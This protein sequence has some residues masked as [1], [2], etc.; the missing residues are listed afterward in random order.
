MR[1]LSALL[2]GAAVLAAALGLAQLLK[3][4][5]AAGPAIAPP[6]GGARYPPA[7]QQQ[8]RAAAAAERGPPRTRHRLPSGAPI[9]TN[10]L[11]LEASPYLQ[12]HAHNP[13]DWFPWGDEAF[14]RAR[15]EHKPVLLSVGYSTCHWCHVMEEESFEDLEIADY[16]N[17]YYVAIKVDRE[18]RP[19]IDA[20]YM[21]AV[22]RMRGGGGWP[23]T[24]WL[25][26]DRQP[27]YGGTYFPPRDGVRGA[28]A[29]FL[30]VL[31]HLRAAYDQRPDDVAAAAADVAAQV[32]DSQTQPAGE[33][34]P[35][36]APLDGAVAA[37]RTQ[38]DATNGGF[39]GAPKFPRSVE[40]QLLL[41][42]YRR[43]GNA[44]ALAM[45]TRTLEAL[46]AGGIRDQIGGGFHRYSTDAGWRVPHFEKMLYDNALLALTFLD[47]CQV[48]GRADFAAVVRDILG[49]AQR[50][51]TAPDGAFYAA[52]DADS[53]GEEGTFFVWTPAE[54]QAVLTPGEWRVARAYY[55]V[56]DAGNFGGKN[57]LHAPRPLA[58]VANELGLP[59]PAAESLLRG[60]RTKLY[61]A[62]LQRVPPHTDHKILPAWNGLM[63]SAFA[64]GAQVL[65]DPADA[66]TAAAAATYV[67]DH[68]MQ[69][70]RLQRSALEGEAGGEAYLDDYAAMIG[71]LLDLYEATFDPRWLRAAIALERVV[72]AHFR[73][74]TDGGYFLSADD[75]EAL[76]VRTKPDYDGAEPSA[77][78][79]MLLDLLRLH[80]LTGDDRYRSRAADLLRAFTTKLGGS[81]DDLP[82]MLGGL[83]F[84]LDRPKEI[85]IA[86]PGGPA[87][88]AP[89][90]DR[91]RAVYLP[92][93]VVTVVNDGNRAQLAP[94]AP[95]VAD[96][97]AHSGK[98][99]AYVCEQRVCALPTA[100][101][102][103]FA[104]QIAKVAPLPD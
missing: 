28:G 1:A 51:M 8:L 73:D 13:V 35:D 55:D 38:F 16:L 4:P 101:P 68:M 27:F 57:V 65:E 19:D 79:L 102:E 11:V 5:P 87:D 47:A 90:L 78:S 37:L 64:R 69:G 83:D 7:L 43:T 76:L 9:Y 50:E 14:T 75:A 63:I 77:N 48:T 54:M 2:R 92:N 74:Q 18:Q 104:R 89:F 72:D 31:H 58:E 95:I 103:L 84:W 39:G 82:A 41:R 80:E 22:Q 97:T 96:K 42:Y 49:Y 34:L 33:R 53:G 45:A 23:M 20:V 60:A 62:R 29:G 71:G 81:P 56:S 70:D 94:L 46:A 6:P 40:L 61:T 86:A 98:P 91:L 32:R 59:V 12:Q 85:V 36:R 24:V 88:A 10:R 3:T 17:R 93:R 15:K 25:T 21:E 66:A 100:D 30:T 99:T 52:T 44:D 26:A 67:L